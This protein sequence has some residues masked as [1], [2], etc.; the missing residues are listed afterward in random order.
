MARRKILRRGEKRPKPKAKRRLKEYF[1]PSSSGV[2]R[3]S[4]LTVVDDAA[5]TPPPPK[6]LPPPKVAELPKPPV[7]KRQR[8]LS[9]LSPEEQS[10]MASRV[11]AK[12]NPHPHVERSTSTRPL[13]EDEKAI[14]RRTPEDR[15][16]LAYQTSVKNRR[17][18]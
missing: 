4:S 6:I 10:A 2:R 3:V 14:V 8:T 17:R 11:A 12:A 15:A 1:P 18:R 9:D 16:W 5:P 13:N 7:L